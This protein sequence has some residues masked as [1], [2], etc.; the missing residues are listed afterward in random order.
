MICTYFWVAQKTRRMV[1]SV[2]KTVRLCP[3]VTPI[4]SPREELSVDNVWQRRCDNGAKVQLCFLVRSTFTPH[5]E[6]ELSVYVLKYSCSVPLGFFF[7]FWNYVPTHAP[8]FRSRL[9]EAPWC[10]ASWWTWPSTRPWPW[11]ISSAWWKPRRTTG[12]SWTSGRPST[13]SV[14]SW[15]RSRCA[16]WSEDTPAWPRISS[17]LWFPTT[18]CPGGRQRSRRREKSQRRRRPS[19]NSDCRR[20]LG[21]KRHFDEAQQ[22][23]FLLLQQELFILQGPSTPRL[24]KKWLILQRS[25]EVY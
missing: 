13:C 20:R 18:S 17:R 3:T 25:N 1:R 9:A 15:W 6:S 8:D 7:S 16:W 24:Q 23:E 10:K 14:C 5:S 4:R 12:W 2:L 21:M 11:C 19:Q 22:S